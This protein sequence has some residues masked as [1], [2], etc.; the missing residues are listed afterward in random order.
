VSGVTLCEEAV[1]R[2]FLVE[3]AREIAGGRVIG[4][5]LVS[6]NGRLRATVRGGA[7]ILER[8]WGKL[9]P[10]GGLALNAEELRALVAVGDRWRRSR[11]GWA[12]W[13]AV[14]HAAGHVGTW[15]YLAPGAESKP[16]ELGR[17][18]LG[19]R[20]VPPPEAR[21]RH[22]PRTRPERVS[23]SASV[24]ADLLL[25]VPPPGPDVE[26]AAGEVI[27]LDSCLEI[28]LRRRTA[29]LRRDDRS[30]CTLEAGEERLLPE[31]LAL[32]T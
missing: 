13:Y 2:P 30:C 1:G 6:P 17:S 16:R 23:A 7:V 11:A 29:A 25:R 26:E 21:E 31:Y 20:E 12:A 14:G 27:R 19:L 18:T 32:L 5:R 22:A 10:P 3:D 24:E 15:H 28:T 4:R 9:G 8:E